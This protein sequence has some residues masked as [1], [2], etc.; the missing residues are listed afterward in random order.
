MESICK[1]LQQKVKELYGVDVDVTDNLLDIDVLN[2]PIVY[3]LYLFDYVEMEFGVK[4]N[5]L[6]E[7]I[8]YE[9]FTIECLSKKIK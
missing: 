5:E 9:M 7:N 6:L 8:T 2:I 3:L 1:K 4:A